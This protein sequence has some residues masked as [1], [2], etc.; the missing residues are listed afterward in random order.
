MLIYN[1]LKNKKQ[2]N[3]KNLTFKKSL[4]KLPLERG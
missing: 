3:A 4:A 1:I 2:T